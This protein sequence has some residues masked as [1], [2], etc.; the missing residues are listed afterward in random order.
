[1]LSLICVLSTRLVITLARHL[2]FKQTQLMDFW[3][4]IFFLNVYPLYIKFMPPREFSTSSYPKI[5]FDIISFWISLNKFHQLNKRNLREILWLQKL[6]YLPKIKDDL[7]MFDLN[8]IFFVRRCHTS[9]DWRVECQ[10]F[11]IFQLFSFSWMRMF[12]YAE[13]HKVIVSEDQACA[14]FMCRTSDTTP[15][16]VPVTSINVIIDNQQRLLSLR[17]DVL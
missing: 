17:S 7:F 11:A 2:L 9:N 14:A 8:S 15:V 13:C 10:L 12:G 5:N 16:I 1:M 3:N 6:F 4:S